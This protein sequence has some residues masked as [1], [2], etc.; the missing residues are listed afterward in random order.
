[1]ARHGITYYVSASGSDKNDGLSAASPWKS[2]ARVGK[3]KY[4]PGDQILLKCGDVWYD[5]LNLGSTSGSKEAPFVLAS[6]GVGPKPRIRRHG[7]LG[8]N[9][10]FFKNPSHIVI[11]DLDCSRAMEGIVLYFTRKGCENITVAACDFHDITGLQYPGETYDGVY[12]VSSA[13]VMIS[14]KWQKTP[15]LKGL[16][17]EY[18]RAYELCNCLWWVSGMTDAELDGKS[19]IYAVRNF[20]G[21]HCYS[22]GGSFGYWMFGVVGGKISNIIATRNG[23]TWFHAGTTGMGVEHCKKVEISHS[24][25]SFTN[26]PNCPDGCGLDLEGGG[27]QDIHVHDCV[28]KHNDSNG[29]M[30]FKK[31]GGNHN[32]IIENNLF[33]DNFEDGPANLK[34]FELLFNMPKTNTNIIVRNN[35][36]HLLKGVSFTNGQG[37]EG[38]VFK[39]N[40]Q[41]KS[42]KDA[43]K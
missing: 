13:G 43:Y 30:V 12:Y 1:M 26:R 29:M 35:R 27:N 9:C 15:L 36:Y 24:E 32:C 21:R 39:N 25:F 34:P 10:V 7:Q 38:C 3:Q 22:E 4:G 11:R 8:M 28:F 23:E 40:R 42:A 5:E 41:L 37:E 2:F 31:G 20:I 17:I 18:C 6:Y 14:G 16:T 33:L 19:G